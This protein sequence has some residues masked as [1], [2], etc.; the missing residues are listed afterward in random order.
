MVIDILN[1]I[2]LDE[3]SLNFSHYDHQY[4]DILT[5]SAQLS[6][7][8]IIA[9]YILDFKQSVTFEIMASSFILKSLQIEK[10]TE[11][12]IQIFFSRKS[13]KEEHVY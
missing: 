8:A 11:D 3:L 7:K 13:G 10:I 5:S 12:Y 6:F 1:D 2:V 4:D 9:K